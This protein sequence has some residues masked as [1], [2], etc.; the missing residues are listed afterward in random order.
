M[1]PLLRERGDTHK[2]RSYRAYTPLS[3][4]PLLWLSPS[5]LHHPPPPFSTPSLNNSTSTSSASGT[6][7]TSSTSTCVH[8]LVSST[9]HILRLELTSVRK[10]FQ[11]IGFAH[12]FRHLD[13]ETKSP[14]PASQANA[15]SHPWQHGLGLWT[16]MRSLRPLL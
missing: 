15:P 12:S 4:S 7:G 16:V 9:F 14:P 5:T 2:C 1:G 11:V 8:I 10:L 13:P 6:S 3:H